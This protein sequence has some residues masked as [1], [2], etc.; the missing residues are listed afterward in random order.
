MGCVIGRIYCGLKI[1]FCLDF[2][3]TSSLPDQLHA[4]TECWQK[5]VPLMIQWKSQ[6][7]HNVVFPKWCPHGLWI[8]LSVSL[9]RHRTLETAPCGILVFISVS[10]WESSW[11]DTEQQVK[12]L[13]IVFRGHDCH[14]GLRLQFLY[15]DTNLIRCNSKHHQISRGKAD[16]DEEGNNVDG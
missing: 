1:W 15:S 2:L 5:L 11:L 9:R 12:L 7:T 8:V 4:D 13:Q 16:R 3:L 10:P 14:F 6:S